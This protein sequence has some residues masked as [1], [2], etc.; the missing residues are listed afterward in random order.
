MSLDDGSLSQEVRRCSESGS[1]N[2]ALPVELD[3]CVASIAVGSFCSHDSVSLLD[4]D[5]VLRDG[6][7]AIVDDGPGEL[8]VDCAR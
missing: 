4:L 5:L 2:Q 6:S 3:G 7:T 1:R 8:D